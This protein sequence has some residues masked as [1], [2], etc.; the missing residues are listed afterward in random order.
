[1]TKIE[2]VDKQ[3]A[4]RP[5]EEIQMIRRGLQQQG[6]QQGFAERMDGRKVELIVSRGDGESV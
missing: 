2:V 3:G 4:S 6:L 1:L 5:Q